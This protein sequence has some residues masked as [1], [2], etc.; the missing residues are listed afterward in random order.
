M[1]GVV[2]GYEDGL[3]QDRLSL[4]MWD[5]SEQ[6]HV[7]INQQ[8]LHFLHVVLKLGDAFS[9]RCIVGRSFV[10]RPVAGRKLRGNVAWITAELENV[11]LADA[12]VLKQLPRGVRASL[13]LDPAKFRRPTREDFSVVQVCVLPVQEPN[14]EFSQR[15]FVVHALSSPRSGRLP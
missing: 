8:S 12:Q 10:G 15:R 14:Q 1:I 9:P 2:I 5:C 4:T 3:A 6:V 7:G 11:P 13:G